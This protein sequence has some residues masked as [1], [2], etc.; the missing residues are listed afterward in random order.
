MTF[1]RRSLIVCISISGC[2]TSLRPPP[3]PTPAAP[4][5][6]RTAVAPA[7]PP[8][9]P[10]PPTVEAESEAVRSK[11]LPLSVEAIALPGATAPVSLDFLFYE[12]GASRVWVPA[13]GTGDVD[14][15]DVAKHAFTRVEGFKTVER[16]AHGTKRMIG[17]SAGAVGDGF[18]YIG[19]RATQEICAVELKSLR[20]AHVSEAAGPD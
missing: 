11:P 2:A 18:A 5:A 17:P 14:V 1:S 10:T 8:P 15:F 12:P 3:A 6:V 19:N 20:R 9:A 13:G 7:T 16:E 4:S